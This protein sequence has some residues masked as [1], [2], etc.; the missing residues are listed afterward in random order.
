MGDGAGA[1]RLRGK[2]VKTLRC[3]RNCKPGAVDHYATGL[4]R[5][6]RRS[7]AKIGKSGNLPSRRSPAG[8]EQPM[9]ARISG[10]SAALRNDRN[11]HRP[12]PEGLT[13][14][15]CRLIIRLPVGCGSKEEYAYFFQL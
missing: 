10:V 8:R 5:P 7:A 3:A 4:I 13:D 1:I 11:V 6:G 15:T 9:V 12:A 2:Q 14:Q